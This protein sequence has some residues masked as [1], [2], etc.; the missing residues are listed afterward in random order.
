MLLLAITGEQ[1]SNLSGGFKLKPIT[2]CHIQ[3][4]YKNI[5]KIL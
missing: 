5:M 2:T 4:Y 3:I 1:K